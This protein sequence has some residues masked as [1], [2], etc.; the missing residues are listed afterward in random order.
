MF[1]NG[2][3]FSIFR[4]GDLLGF[5]FFPP[6][7]PP[8]PS[9]YFLFFGKFSN[10][11]WGGPKLLGCF[12]FP[13]FFWA[14]PNVFIKNT[15]TAR[16]FEYFLGFLDKRYLKKRALVQIGKF[17]I[18]NKTRGG[19]ETQ[20]LFLINGGNQS[21]PSLK[22]MIFF[23]YFPFFLGGPIFSPHHFLFFFPCSPPQTP[24][25]SQNLGGGGQWF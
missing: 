3:V 23:F 24:P 6:A 16:F 17:D 11:G 7:Q 2:K 18:K 10:G 5:F 15:L 1:L 8:L 4:F 25:P 12:F 13:K 14:A 19:G 9:P 20:P 21:P 22:L